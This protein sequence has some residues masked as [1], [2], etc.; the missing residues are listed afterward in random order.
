MESRNSQ[1][2]TAEQLRVQGIALV[3]SAAEDVCT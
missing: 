3:R 1:G 2:T